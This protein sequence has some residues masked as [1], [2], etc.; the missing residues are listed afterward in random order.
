MQRGGLK[1]RLRL[2]FY[3]DLDEL[4]PLIEA[5]GFK[6]RD[7]MPGADPTN[8]TTSISLSSP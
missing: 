6:W 4:R 1:A 5:A 3:G 7:H 8:R 2:Y